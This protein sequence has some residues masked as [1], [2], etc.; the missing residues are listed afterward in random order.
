MSGKG[1]NGWLTPEGK[2]YPCGLWENSKMADRLVEKFNLVSE[3]RRACVDNPYSLL[4]FSHNFLR[5]K[6]MFVS[7]VSSVNHS[8]VEMCIDYENAEVHVTDKQI[9]W[10]QDNHDELSATQQEVLVKEFQKCRVV[11]H[12]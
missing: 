12:I 10:L 5:R 3:K 2:F 6:K 11:T 1:V 9:K 8:T 4:M 7:L